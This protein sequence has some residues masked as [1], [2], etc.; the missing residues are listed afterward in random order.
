MCE[1]SIFV[2]ILQAIG[3]LGAAAVVLVGFAV[4][5]AGF[6]LLISDPCEVE[7]DDDETSEQIK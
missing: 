6:A 4:V 1:Q 5:L 2:Y 7:V 3:A